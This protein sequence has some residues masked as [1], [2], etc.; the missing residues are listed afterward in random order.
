MKKVLSLLA[1]SLMAFFG[2]A[3]TAHAQTFPERDLRI[4]VGFVAGSGPDIIARF[5]GTKMQTALGRPVIVENRPGALGNIGNEAVA[6]ARPD[7]Y[8]MLFNGLST[9][10]G[11]MAMVKN[12]PI[13]ASKTLEVVGTLA[14]QPHLVV[15]GPNS[16]HQSLASLSEALKQK[17]KNGSYGTAYPQARIIGAMYTGSLGTGNVE[18]QY[19]TSRDWLN[20]LASGS[21]DFAVVETGAGETMAQQNQARVLAISSAVRTRTLPK[22]ATLRES[23]HNIVIEGIWG[24]F[25]PL[26]TPKPIIDHLNRV[27]SEAAN[28]AEGRAFFANLS[29][30]VATMSPAEAQAVF[31]KELKDW[32]EF[33]RIAKIE[34][35]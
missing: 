6:R 22:Y 34:Q 26:G 23:G 10:A 35:Q 21:L 29:I 19:R 2:G 25:V 16:P 13:D 31:L 14:R 33:V 30:D 28:S 4:V 27:M 7:G 9:V 5:V 11:A 8:T 32:V 1:L 18:V 17:G 3:A 15:V 12:P 20:D 24:I